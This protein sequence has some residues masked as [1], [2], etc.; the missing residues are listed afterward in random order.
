M[1]ARMVFQARL[2]APAIAGPP[3]RAATDGAAR[4]ERRQLLHRS[5]C[6]QFLHNMHEFNVEKPDYASTLMNSF[7]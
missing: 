6:D 5:L 2:S 3:P 7:T 4:N 1:P